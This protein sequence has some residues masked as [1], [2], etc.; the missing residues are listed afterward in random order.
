MESSNYE[1]AVEVRDAIQELS[2]T[3]EMGFEGLSGSPVLEKRVHDLENCL[4]EVCERLSAA[5][6]AYG[7]GEEPVKLAD[8]CGLCEELAQ[9]IKAHA[10]GS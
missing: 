8:L 7:Y 10:L 1:C 6:R 4:S 9:T 5:A 3:V 2:R